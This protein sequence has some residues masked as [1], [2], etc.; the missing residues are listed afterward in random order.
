MWGREKVGPCLGQV[1]SQIN[2][3]CFDINYFLLSLL[4]N[5]LFFRQ[6]NLLYPLEQAWSL[7]IPAELLPHQKDLAKVSILFLAPKSE[8]KSDPDFGFYKF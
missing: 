2:M 7:G 3:P 5:P 6:N 8:L 4:I 1:K